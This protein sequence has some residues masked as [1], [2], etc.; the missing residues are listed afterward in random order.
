MFHDYIR[1]F[2]NRKTAAYNDSLSPMLLP[3][4]LRG[5]VPPLVT[6]L[7]GRDELDYE[8]LRRLLQ[9]LMDAGCHGVFVLGSTGEAQA[10]SYRLR[11]EVV[12]ETCRIVDGRIPV[13][14]GITDTSLVE[15]LE[16]GEFCIS[17]GVSGLVVAPPYY[18][19]MAQRDLVRHAESLAAEL[20]R[21]LFLYNIPGL[22]K[23]GWEPE[24]V[25]EAAQIPGIAGLKD[26]SADLIYLQRV[27]RLTAFRADFSVL[28]GP[29]EILGQA[30]MLGA[31]GGVC[32]GANLS[33]ELYVQLWSAAQQK[34]YD[35]V[36]CLGRKVMELSEALYRVGDPSTSY[37]RGIKYALEV[38]GICSGLPAP[39]LEPF[40]E[41]EK[42][43]IRGWFAR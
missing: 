15:S 24:T 7:T 32:G 3:Q 35:E 39:P 19:R 4:P 21:P 36:V 1:C 23:L 13:L 28:V 14:A 41:S 34:R 11:K 26:S 29:E 2:I 38:D 12:R 8:G 22:T 31:H 10:L 16:F 37:F 18:F 30:M 42:A 5:I 9:R 6:P 40:T 25:A 33:P 43:V 20:P 27:L 17:A